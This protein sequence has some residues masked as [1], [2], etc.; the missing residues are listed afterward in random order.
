MRPLLAA[1]LLL[2]SA[3]MAEG[4][5]QLDFASPLTTYQVFWGAIIFIVLY[6]LA[7]RLA[8]PQV[9]SVLE[10][11]AS[12]IARDL[13]DAQQ[14]K[15]KSDQAAAEVAAATARARA[16]AQAAINAALDEAKAAAAAQAATLNQRL[17]QQL[18][19]AEAR[20]AEARAS[21]M[22]ALRQVATQTAATVITRLTGAPVEP[23]RLN[24]AITAALSARGAG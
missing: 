1:L 12:N 3:A 4:M 20:I 17:E 23:A 16:D 2:P 6:V 7:S 14:A 24:G 5:P 18:A 10:E 15:A 11:R 19:D 13:D 9:A 22:G 8:L 21:A